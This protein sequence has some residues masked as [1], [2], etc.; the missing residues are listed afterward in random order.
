MTTPLFMTGFGPRVVSG[1]SGLW[2]NPTQ[3]D[4]TIDS[5][6]QRS[7]RPTLRVNAV[8]GT[9]ARISKA[10][11]EAPPLGVFRV[12]VQLPS[13]PTTAATMFML[14]FTSTGGAGA[15]RARYNPANGKFEMRFGATAVTVGTVSAVAGQWHVFDVRINAGVSPMSCDWRVDGVAQPSF[16]DPGAAAASTISTVQLGTTFTTEVFTANFTDVVLSGT[17]ADYPMGDS[18]IVTKLPLPAPTRAQSGGGAIQFSAD[19]GA[20]YADVPADANVGQYLRAQPMDDTS[21]FLRQSVVGAGAFVETAF[22]DL[23]ASAIRAVRAVLTYSSDSTTGTNLA[24]A[25]IRRADGT[26]VPLF[27]T[28]TGGGQVN[29]GGYFSP[30]FA[31][32]IIP[33]PAG[34]WTVAEVNALTARVGYA[35]DVTPTPRWHNLLLEVDRDVSVAQFAR[36]ISVVADS[37]GAWTGAVA[38]IAEVIPDDSTAIVS[39]ADPAIGSYREVLLGSI[40]APG[41]TTGHIVHVRYG[42]VGPKSTNLTV[43]LRQGASTV[44]ASWSYTGLAPGYVQRDETLTAAQAGAITNYADLRLRFLPSVV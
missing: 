24:A 7:G 13:L 23:P 44:I 9:Y 5:A 14:L 35:S 6:V 30:R 25:V 2:I 12:A 28:P 21:Q 33:P 42:P 43:Q 27:G 41:T 10:I 29:Y 38:D 34:G 16:T 17:T 3:G 26:L 18:Q 19:S 15:L 4:V 39:P 32:A 22:V 36:P 11:P 31:E 8:S 40:G 20:T 1:T 37:G